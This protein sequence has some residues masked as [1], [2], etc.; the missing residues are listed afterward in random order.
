MLARFDATWGVVLSTVMLK[1]PE[2]FLSMISSM[3][4]NRIAQCLSANNTYESTCLIFSIQLS[5]MARANKDVHV[6]HQS[7]T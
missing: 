4:I 1:C 6:R 2:T 7:D 5:L 3:N